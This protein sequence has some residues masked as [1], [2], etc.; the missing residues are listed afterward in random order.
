MEEKGKKEKENKVGWV[1]QWG[2]SG[3]SR[4]TR[5]HDEIHCM[6]NF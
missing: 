5:K 2:G 4:G 1:G 6:K 3:M